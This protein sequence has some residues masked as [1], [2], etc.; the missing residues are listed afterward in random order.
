M[1]ELAQ[2][3][4]LAELPTTLCSIFPDKPA[5]VMNERS[6]TY[7]ELDRQSGDIARALLRDGLETG[8]RV[9]VFGRDSMEGLS[10]FFGVAR[11]KCVC[12]PINWRLA[13]EETAY[14]IKHSAPRVLFVDQES[15]P[16]VTAILEKLGEPLRVI[17]MGDIETDHVKF[18]HWVLV[19][20]T[21]LPPFDY[22]PDD[23]VVQMY[24]S[25]TTGHPKG[26]QL[27]HRTFFGIA[28]ALREHD[29]PW[30]DWQSNDVQMVCLPSFHI[31]GL[32]C[33]ARGL[34]LGNTN[35]VLRAFDASAVLAAVPRH[36]VTVL[37]MVPA[38][39]QVVL[40]E[41]DCATTDFSSLRV[42]IYGGSPIST[43]LLEQAMK[44]FCR[45]FVQFYGLTETGNV[46]VSLRPADHYEGSEQ[47]L[48]A[49]GR[50]LPGVMVRVLDSEG[51]EVPEGVIGEIAI[52][53]PARMV[54]YW[55]APEA[56]AKTLV[57]GW[58]MTG[59]AGYADAQG[60]IYLCDRIKDMVIVAGENIYPAEIEE[61]IRKHPDVVDAA[62]IGVPDDMWGEAIKAFVVL[63]PDVKVRAA[64]IIRM[65]RSKL[66][67][68]KAPKSVEFVAQ[69]PRNASGK[70][71]KN[72]LRE[73]YWKERSR[74]IN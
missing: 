45:D 71:L 21:P 19:D 13:A 52:R 70:L 22:S 28:R 73:P 8:D 1:N 9:A 65:T 24:T 23:V 56:T 48:R 36:R 38:M 26:V 17:V 14:I 67:D 53:S 25:G 44:A 5:L 43:T 51:R 74:R 46:A 66:A 62:V 31:G 20:D 58:I 4:T 49:A 15:L 32:W 16:L 61:V 34:A 2:L 29:D 6:L 12:V 57:D 47:R 37:L 33:I 10:L 63:R 50:P 30:F 64:D 60:Y 35:I 39:M 41:P 18:S 42:M 3:S 68:F 54:G 40:R 55:N 27:A 7:A 72:K 11:A 59:D 69:L